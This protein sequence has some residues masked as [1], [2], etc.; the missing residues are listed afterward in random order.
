M[1][2]LELGQTVRILAN[3]GVLVGLILLPCHL[4]DHSHHQGSS[5]D[6]L[7]CRS[8]LTWMLIASSITP[9]CAWT[10]RWLVGSRIGVELRE[11]SS[12]TSIRG[13]YSNTQEV[14][15]LSAWKRAR[16]MGILTFGQV[17]QL[18]ARALSPG[19]E[20]SRS[21]RTTIMR[22]ARLA[23]SECLQAFYQN[24][25]ASSSIGKVGTCLIR[26]QSSL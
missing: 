22:A 26:Q 8:S 1:K 20:I 23:V 14:S 25:K 10:L 15:L 9:E 21:L 13:N 17:C 19:P 4:I 6:L 16:D 5:L 7:R 3:I 18:R 12:V 11:V 2:K 24:F